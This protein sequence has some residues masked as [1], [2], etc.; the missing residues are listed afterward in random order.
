[1]TIL[2]KSLQHTGTSKT[3][4]KKLC[5]KMMIKLNNDQVYVFT[6]IIIN[7]QVMEIDQENGWWETWKWLTYQHLN[8]LH[9][10]NV[11]A[12]KNRRSDIHINMDNNKKL[13]AGNTVNQHS[14]VCMKNV[15]RSLEL[16]SQFFFLQQQQQ[17]CHNCL[18]FFFL[19]EASSWIV[20]SW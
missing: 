18:P 10:N 8:N 13:I 3:G 5:L 2:Y 6:I 7:I 15:K 20:H 16:S 9:Q 14:F 19:T 11:A 17:M 12:V 4:K 1:M